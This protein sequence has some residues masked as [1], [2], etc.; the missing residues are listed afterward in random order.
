MLPG[1]DAHGRQ[2]TLSCGVALGHLRAAVAAEGWRAI[3]TYFP[4]PNRGDHLATIGFAPTEIV[5]DA[6]C[7]RADA[8]LRR[9][10]DRLPLPPPE[11]WDVFETVL[12][13]TF[14][15]AD[16][17]LDVLS[18]DSRPCRARA[19]GL[20]AALRRY[21]STY[22]AELRWW[23]GHVIGD[24]GIVPQA[25]TS[26]E[27]RA[28]VPVGRAFPA[29]DAGPRR[30]GVVDQAAVLVLSTDSDS[31]P[32]LLRCGEV[33]STILLECTLAGYATCPL[34]HL[35]EIARSRAAVGALTGRKLL[36]QIL[37]RVGSMPE[38]ADETIPTPRLSL[39]KVLISDTSDFPAIR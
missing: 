12:R 19:S 25:L 22:H 30:D 27:E 13:T 7:E 32:D 15:P 10:T 37:I 34:T 28:R 4:D 2:M 14:D 39:D 24:V 11:G 26:T 1:T 6:E 20:T 3:V 17:T 29:I 38:T 36:P 8:I 16:A 21:D 18:E 9:R 33:L 5:T 35:T 31:G 23:A